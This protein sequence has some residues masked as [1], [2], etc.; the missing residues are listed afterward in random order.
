MKASNVILLCSTLVGVSLP[1]TSCT[2][3]SQ[4]SSALRCEVRELGVIFANPT[5]YRGKT[6]CGVVVGV[7]D[8]VSI[9][10]YPIGYDYVHN[11]YDRVM[12]LDDRRASDRL[13]LS[14]T[15]PFR[16]HVEGTISL[17][18]DC[19]SEETDPPTHCSPVRYPIT[20]R[21]ARVGDPPQE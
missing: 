9:L 2:T 20:L 5:E 3:A 10:F 14:Q 12:F 17:A 16:I 18:E 21:V 13:R 6:F 8:R 11:R 19:F 1:A 15:R 4:R 7:P